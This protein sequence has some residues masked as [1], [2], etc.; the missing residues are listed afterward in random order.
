MSMMEYLGF[1]TKAIEA[2]AEFYENIMSQ[3]G[4]PEDETYMRIKEATYSTF[5]VDMKQGL[6][7]VYDFNRL[8]KIDLMFPTNIIIDAIVRHTA[9]ALQD[10]F[11]LDDIRVE[12]GNT[13]NKN[14]TH[15]ISLV[16]NGTE[17]TAQNAVEI[18]ST[19]ND[20]GANKPKAKNSVDRDR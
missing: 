18:M 13:E 20:G 10:R 15:I 8:S 9:L 2:T 16:I 4:F 17:L 1:D 3:A 7:Y 12:Y 14:R 5:Y 11:P 19:L 6:R